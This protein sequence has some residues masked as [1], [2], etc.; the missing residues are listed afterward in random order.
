MIGGALPL[1]LAFGCSEQVASLDAGVSSVD[2]RAEAADAAGSSDATADADAETAPR[3]P[4]SMGPALGARRHANGDL[5]V[6]VRAPSAT[7]VEVCL[8]RAPQGEPERLRLPLAAEE[9]RFALRIGR[10]ELDGA[11]LTD[12]LFYGFRVWG[13]NWGH[14]PAWTPGS[15]VGFIADVD[16]D[17]FRMNPNKVLLD[18]YA[19]EVSHD[20]IGPGQRHGR[21]YDPGDGRRAIDTA[22]IA[23][24]GVVIEVLPPAVPG[25]SRPLREE[26]IYEVHLR[27]LTAA[28]PSLGAS[29]G[30]YEGARA[31]ARSLRDLGVTAIELLPLHETNNDQ[32]ELTP[33]AAG[34]NYWGYSTIN[35]FAPDRR[36]ARDRSPGGP[37]RELRAMI[38]AFHQEGLKV[39]AD[40]VYNHTAEGS[41]ALWSFRGFGSPTYYEHGDDPTRY[42]NGNGV[43]P[44]VNTADPVVADL[45]MSSLRYWHEILGVD[46]FRFDLAPIVGNGCTRGCYRFEPG[47]LLARI[48]RE[49]PAR[50]AAGGGGVDLIAEPWGVI[51]GS[52]QLG[53]FPEGWA[54]WNDRYRDTIRRDLNRLGV[55]AVTPR[56]LARR[57]EGSPDIFGGRA[58]RGTINFVVA[59]DGFTLRDLFAYNQ[60]DNDQPW[61]YGPSGGGSDGNLS[62]DFG[63][64]VDRQRLAARTALAL[65]AVSAGA[66]MIAGGDEFLRSQ[67][68]NNNPY[69]LDS[70]AMW[71]DP[72]GPAREPDFYAFARRLFAF[73]NAHASLRPVEPWPAATDRDADGVPV[74]RW[75][76]EGGRPVDAAYL[77]SPDRHFIAWALDSDELGD[78]EGALYI[79]YNGWSGP[80]AARPPPP[81]AGGRWYVFADTSIA[82][83][84]WQNAH[85]L[86]G[87]VPLGGDTLDVAG[88]GLVILVAR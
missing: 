57:I 62:W 2:A 35:F 63:G 87:L 30:T 44:N 4:W 18:P 65:L 75:L 74:L 46:G 29:A 7:R 39:Y 88:R 27:G 49:L 73:R 47:G 56:D 11:G 41:R 51:A 15:E 68:G 43:G 52:Y 55:E 28:D 12:P 21:V 9:D 77:D 17:G 79:A 10:V 34:D 45:V 84:R 61:P 37:T 19:L 40:V 36:Y 58:I 53:R 32:N 50:P 83:E 81:P 8:F 72:E 25:P 33:D 54:E 26:I 66:P 3:D 42:E 70:P 71:L 31:R 1:A 5:E 69:N 59:H 24:K 14:E 67:R 23:P 6:R 76:T 16:G 22:T 13:P 20:P 78:P 82:A 64:Q 86:D 80:I 48:A 38:E 85:P 60:K